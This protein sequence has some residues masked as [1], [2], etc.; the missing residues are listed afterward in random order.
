MKRVLF[1]ILAISGWSYADNCNI[2]SPLPMPITI[3]GCTY[4]NSLPP[5]STSYIQNT[6]TPST[7]YQ[8]FSVAIASVSSSI[9]DVGLASNATQCV[10]VST[11]GILQGTGSACGSGGGSPNDTTILPLP[12]GAT[13]YHEE[14]SEI[15]LSSGVFGVLGVSTG[16]TP[17]LPSCSGGSNALTWNTGSGTWGCNTI[18][19]GGGG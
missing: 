8:Q 13:N 14:S 19:G 9:T 12:D 18:S 15:S 7:T 4:A 5:N 1:F 10:Q 17:S 6:L 2:I 16:I 3:A 11:A